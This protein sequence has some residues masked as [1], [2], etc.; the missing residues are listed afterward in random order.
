M[1]ELA[2]NQFKHSR[3]RRLFPSRPFYSKIG[4]LLLEERG[5]ERALAVAGHLQREGSNP[6]GEPAL[7]RTIAPSAALVGTLAQPR[8]GRSS[9]PAGVGSKRLKQRCHAV[10]ALRKILD[11]L[12]TGCNLNGRHRY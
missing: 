2:W 11:L 3:R 7:V 12:L 6:R 1:S 4:T 9:P 8:D 5:L 10:V